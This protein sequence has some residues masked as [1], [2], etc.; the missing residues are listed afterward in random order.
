MAEVTAFRNNALPYPVY[1]VPWTIVFPLLDADGDP[2]TGATCD[3]EVSKNGD[4]GADCTNEGVEIT[5]TTATNKGM[6]YLI[7]TA[8]EMTADIVTVTIYSATSK[9]TCIVLYPR[10]LVQITTGT[11]QGGAAGYITLAAGAVAFNGQYNGCLCVATIDTLV[12]ARILQVCTASN[13]QCT[14]TPGWNVTPD[15][16]DTYIIYLPE[17]MQFPTANVKAISDGAAAADNLESA[18]DNYSATR[19]LSGTALPAAAADAAG[20]L[21]ISDAGGLDMDA[22]KVRTDRIPNAVAG[23]A[24]GLFIAGSNAATTVASWTCTA[25]STNGSTVFGNT[26][27]GTLTQTGAVSLGATTIA[28]AAITG[29]LSVGTTTTFTGIITATAAND[30]RGVKP[31][32]GGIIAASFGA[33]A[34]D[35]AAIADGAIDNATFA[36]DV[37]STAYATNIIAL[38]V[39]KVL[40]ELHLNH[41]LKDAT[42]GADMTTEVAD[43]T[44]LARVLANGD[45]SAFDP[46]TDGLQPIKDAEVTPTAASKTGYALSATGLDA[47]VKMKALLDGTPAGSVVDDN[48]PDPLATAFETDLAEASNDHY[49]GA[50]CVFYSGAL[51]GQSRKIS[52]YDGTTKVLTVASAFTEAP[53]AGDDFLIIGRSE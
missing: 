22:V 36:A 33:G 9:A 16:D 18:C 17:G 31:A 11:S 48:D 40:D 45:T 30:I 2:V 38:A 52:D 51:A 14:V 21:P 15:S 10:K 24:G 28:S 43:N 19:G 46:S 20:G 8:A 12:E 4:T 5:Y 42:A 26:T 50:F 32:A 39:R 6:Y 37:G 7:L 29:A 49:N 27:I 23:A 44:I 53:A 47:V 13:Q 25:A 34:I 3:S 35:A 1:G 41:L